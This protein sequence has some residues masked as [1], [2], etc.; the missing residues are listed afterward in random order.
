M[1]FLDWCIE[2]AEIDD[3]YPI[4]VILSSGKVY[5]PEREVPRYV[6]ETLKPL[7]IIGEPELIDGIW[8]VHLQLR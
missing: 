7:E 4:R 2:G 3:N 8:Q 6:V 1:T 5:E